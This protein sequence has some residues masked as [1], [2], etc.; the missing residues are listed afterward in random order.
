LFILPKNWYQKKRK[1]KRTSGH[2]ILLGKDYAE[3]RAMCLKQGSNHQLGN[4]SQASWRSNNVKNVGP[5]IYY[6]RDP[7]DAGAST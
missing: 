2:F 7:L 5:L 6:F 1:E 3:T 4:G